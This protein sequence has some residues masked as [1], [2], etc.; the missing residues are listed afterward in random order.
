M[1][2][3]GTTNPYLSSLPPDQLN[4][5]IASLPDGCGAHELDYWD[6][7]TTKQR[8]REVVGMQAPSGWLLD[9]AR[10]GMA[11]LPD[12]ARNPPSIY[13]Q[14]A[15]QHSCINNPFRIAQRHKTQRANVRIV[16]CAC[17]GLNCGVCGPK[18]KDDWESCLMPKVTDEDV[19][20]EIVRVPETEW[21]TRLQR[22]RRQGAQYARFIRGRANDKGQ[23]ADV[24]VAEAGVDASLATNTEHTR[25]YNVLT[26]ASIGGLAVDGIGERK[27]VLRHLLLF[28]PFHKGAVSVSKGWRPP[29]DTGQEGGTQDEWEIIPRRNGKPGA[30][31]MG[32]EERIQEVAA[33]SKIEYIETR[34]EGDR[35]EMR[36]KVPADMDDF[37]VALWVDRLLD[38]PRGSPGK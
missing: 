28:A 14:F 10:R 29:K 32:S 23:L 31:K 17:H 34:D 30:G 11:N 21:R 1:S 8:I 13:L 27:K 20:L 36:F 19:H 18:R 7:A 9:L 3:A 35:S 25:V 24:L 12:E 37:H 38:R 6:E 5:I 26:T 2:Y 15:P 4:A 16:G 33:I 22:I